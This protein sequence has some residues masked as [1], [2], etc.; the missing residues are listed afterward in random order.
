[1]PGAAGNMN[2]TLTNTVNNIINTGSEVLT[3]MADTL[4]A[5][6]DYV[7]FGSN[8]RRHGVMGLIMGPIYESLWQNLS[9]IISSMLGLTIGNYCNFNERMYGYMGRLMLINLWEHNTTLAMLCEGSSNQANGNSREI[10]HE[11][12]VPA[13]TRGNNYLETVRKITEYENGGVNTTNTDVSDGPYNRVHNLFPDDNDQRRDKFGNDDA[14]DVK[15]P[16]SILY[17]TKCLF[18]Q[19]KINTLISRYGTNTE[20]NPFNTKIPVSGNAVTRFGLSHGNNLLTKLA[21][22][23]KEDYRYDVN[24]YNNPYCRVW[25]H[26]KKYEK[27]IDTMRPFKKGEDTYR[28]IKDVHNWGSRFNPDKDSKKNYQTNANLTVEA[29]YKNKKNDKD[30]IDVYGWKQDARWDKTVLSGRGDGLINITPHFLGGGENNIH[31]KDCMFSIENLAW[32]DYDPYSFETALSWEQRGPLGGRIMWFPPYGLTFSENTNA[33]W[34]SNTFIGRGEDVYTYVNTKRTGTLSFYMIVD[35]PSVLDYVTWYEANRENVSD[36]DIMRYFAG[37][38]SSDVNDPNSLLFY[39]QPTPLTDEGTGGRVQAED[40]KEAKKVEP[41]EQKPETNEEKVIFWTFFPNNYSGVFDAADGSAMGVDFVIQ[42]LLAGTNAQ[43]EYML[44]ADKKDVTLVT[45]KFNDVSDMV[46]NGYEMAFG[47]GITD[48]DSTYNIIGNVK[49]WKN[50]TKGMTKYEPDENKI[51]KYRIDGEYKIPKSD[52]KSYSTNLYDEKLTS[53]EDLKNYHLNCEKTNQ[54]PLYSEKYNDEE[55]YTFSEVVQAIAEISENGD[56]TG[57]GLIRKFFKQSTRVSNDKERVAKLKKRFL[58]KDANG[59]SLLERI[60]IESYSSNQGSKLRNDYLA[61]NRGETI[62]KWLLNAMPQWEKVK[63][64]TEPHSSEG[65]Q[66]LQTMPNTVLQAKLYRS[67]KCT[68]LFRS[69][70]TVNG[71]D[72]NEEN[73]E[74]EGY[75]KDDKETFAGQPVWHLSSEK[76]NSKKS[77]WVLAGGDSNGVGA[78]FYK[79]P[80]ND[81]ESRDFAGEEFWY[82]TIQ[83]GGYIKKREEDGLD[84]EC[85]NDYKDTLFNKIRYDQEYHFFRK[86]KETNPFKF[87]KLMEKLQYFDPAFHSMTPEGFNARL[88]FLHQCTRQGNTVG[89]SDRLRSS[90][91]NM[92]F[93]RP[94][95]CVLRVGDFYNQMIVIDSINFDYETNSGIT[96]DMNDEGVGVQPMLARVSMN[97]TF[98]GGGSLDGPIRRLQNAMSFNFYSNSELYDNRADRVEYDYDMELEMGAVKKGEIKSGDFHNV[99]NYT[100]G[101]LYYKGEQVI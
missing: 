99:E 77:K 1:M 10:T 90:A 73:S 83:K 59:N 45:K 85:R 61:K 87:E 26:H 67:T 30:I 98:I 63:G 2:D 32:K 92:A 41:K 86:M 38:D 78:K 15:D 49:S 76:N 60:K 58:E 24:G 82:K 69:A 89:A 40:V 100:D 57:V 94:P 42:Y 28:D 47:N 3:T 88:T 20:A 48:P 54:K 56:D 19:R 80:E 84:P 5:V 66:E 68:L 39:T 81:N 22:N 95:F 21:E 51:W 93:G 46:G 17:K 91:S 72:T 13:Y 55:I 35:H 27:Y 9:A 31:A 12:Q 53:Y 43:Q 52:V 14:W 33:Q 44:S 7:V 29:E 70:E 97:F 62:K 71:T 4:N 6:G 34:A 25:T 75:Y 11:A 18:R 36:T 16:N 79:L 37:C 65:G 64:T 74:Y 96:W 101:D 50:G 8:D 23:G